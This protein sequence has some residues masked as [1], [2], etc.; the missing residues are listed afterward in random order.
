MPFF[1]LH[2]MKRHHLNPH[3]SSGEGPV[4]EGQYMYF[5][6][7]IKRA[8]TG[9]EMHYH[10]NE[11]MTFP[12]TGKINCVVGKER[13]IVPPGTFVH[14]PSC[15]RHSFRATEDGEVQYLYIKDRTWT[16]IGSAADESL[17][18]EAP[19]ATQ[20]AKALKEGKWPGR[21]KDPQKSQAIIEG[22]GRCFYPM[23]DALDAPPASAHCEQWVEG[24]KLAFGLVESPAG[25][26]R[27]SEASPHEMFI[28]VIRGALDAEVDGEKKRAASGDLIHMP[29]GRA[30]R[31]KVAGKDFARYAMVRSTPKLEAEIERNGAADNWRG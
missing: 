31:W 20:V 18:D 17:P 6:I 1:R 10:P 5:R 11:L 8:G 7:N 2:E 4:I 9:S 26:A 13:Q 23:I 16:L 27:A 28:Y 15:A 14:V 25:Y 21:D 29:K 24:E 12:I 30:W 3:L 22:L 19:S